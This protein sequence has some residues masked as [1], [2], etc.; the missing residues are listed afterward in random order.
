MQIISVDP[1]KVDATGRLRAINPDFVA[2]LAVTMAERGMDSP[3]KVTV[4][5]ASGACKLIAGGHRLAAAISLGWTSVFAIP[6]TGTALQAELA[7]IEENLVRNEL[8]E[9]DRS[10]FLA[11]HKAVWE[12]LHPEVKHGGDRRKK[13][14][15]KDVHLIAERFSA[16]AAAK[17]GVDERTIRR[18]VRRHEAL[19]PTVRER[20]GGTW[21]AES[22]AAI[23]A[24]ISGS[25]LISDVERDEVLDLLL[26]PDSGVRNVLAA[27]HRVRKLPAVD[28]TDTQLSRLMGAWRDANAEARRRFLEWASTPAGKSKGKA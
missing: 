18:A 26:D 28:P 25:T 1:T 24:L 9:L 14:V 27:L 21:I 15:D 3:I 7:E 10:T 22:G 17:L 8:S 23:D 13:Q 2:G 5:D 4:P 19:S 20:I 16:A 12:A 11:R 6:F